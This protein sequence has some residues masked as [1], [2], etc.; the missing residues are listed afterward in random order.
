VLSGAWILAVLK[1]PVLVVRL[2][3]RAVVWAALGSALV[4]GVLVPW[5]VGIPGFIGSGLLGVLCGLVC[6]ELFINAVDDGKVWRIASGMLAV[7]TI[8]AV[9]WV[10][11]VVVVEIRAWTA[12]TVAK[13]TKVSGFETA[14]GSFVAH[15]RSA[16]S[17]RDG[18]S[19]ARGSIP[20]GAWV[21]VP[22]GAYL[23]GHLG[24]YLYGDPGGAWNGSGRW[25]RLPAFEMMTR[26]VT[27]GEY[28]LFLTAMHEEG[29]ARY[30]HPQQPSGKD[31]TPEFWCATDSAPVEWRHNGEGYPEYPVIGVDWFDAYAYARWVG[32]RLPS[33][34]E[35]EKACR[36]VNGKYW[37]WG[38]G[39]PA[40]PVANLGLEEVDDGSEFAA[41]GGS[42]GDDKS[43]FGI[44]DMAG[45]VSEWCDGADRGASRE[46]IC[47]FSWRWVER[48]GEAV[49]ISGLVESR[50]ARAPWLGFRCVRDPDAQAMSD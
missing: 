16:G 45:N 25:R 2:F 32:G 50:G 9:L 11:T 21:R 36:G 13:G 18:G 33:V 24:H 38:S 22:S 14:L 42:S 20:D 28:A 12:A 27:N 15:L 6:L 3:A 49:G 44:L 19:R 46:P 43:T 41:P 47:G 7:G 17:R 8:A 10:A 26:E 40:S 5:F 4:L 23:S 31:H 34:A 37:P 39:L 48:P 29:D 1:V 35:W 30:R